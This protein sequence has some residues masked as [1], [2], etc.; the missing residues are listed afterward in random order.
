MAETGLALTQGKRK[1]ANLLFTAILASRA[2]T[3]PVHVSLMSIS[4][5]RKLPAEIVV[6]RFPL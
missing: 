4:S 2:W 3:F 1:R 6:L 5:T